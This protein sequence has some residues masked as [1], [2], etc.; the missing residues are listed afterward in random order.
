MEKN[1]LYETI[2][3]RKSIRNYDLTP[4]DQNT[5]AKISE[6]MDSLTPINSDIKVELKI[7]SPEQC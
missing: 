1:E 3:K 6:Y 2:F 7:I 5:L 4:L